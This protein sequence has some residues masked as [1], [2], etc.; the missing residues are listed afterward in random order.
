MLGPRH[1]IANTTPDGET[2][3]LTVVPE[4]VANSWI[5]NVVAGSMRVLAIIEARS[6]SVD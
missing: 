6:V 1:A 2:N 4:G 5:V 3:S